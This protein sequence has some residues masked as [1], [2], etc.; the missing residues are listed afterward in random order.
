[1][2]DLERTQEAGAVREHDLAPDNQEDARHDTH[3]R[4]H[5]RDGEH[6]ETKVGLGHEDER[7]PRA[8]ATKV[9]T[10]RLDIDVTED[11]VVNLPVLRR[12]LLLGRIGVRGAV[13]RDRKWRLVLEPRHDESSV[14]VCATR[15]LISLLHRQRG[16]HTIA[17]TITPSL[18]AH[19][20]P[21][22]QQVFHES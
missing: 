21:A 1:M 19:A 6:A 9:R 15:L 4:K 20:R 2:P 14:K 12:G 18:A 22:R 16:H 5:C 13:A 7:A 10:V 17:L 3:D 11:G 8:H